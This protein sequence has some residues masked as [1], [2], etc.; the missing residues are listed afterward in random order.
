MDDCERLCND[1]LN[2][3]GSARRVTE[4]CQPASNIRLS[5]LLHTLHR[6]GPPVLS[7]V[8][9][10]LGKEVTK[11]LE[12]RGP[13]VLTSASG[14]KTPSDVTFKRALFPPHS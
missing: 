7:I 12:S 11:C 14:M 1:V 3:D 6:T 5:D 8:V 2:V 10:S 9:A 4:C 13:C